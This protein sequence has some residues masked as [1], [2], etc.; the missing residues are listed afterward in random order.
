MLAEEKALWIVCYDLNLTN[1]EDL[2]AI[3]EL[4]SKAQEKGIKVYGLSSAGETLSNDFIQKHKLNFD[5]YVTD[6]IVLKTM[7]RS[8]P[9]IMYLENGTVKGKWH[10]SNVPAV[11]ELR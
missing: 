11:D 10:H 6:G 2:K 5:F 9:G 1:T 7:V 4:T 3:N 8:N